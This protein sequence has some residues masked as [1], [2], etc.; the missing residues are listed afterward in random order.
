MV[1]QITGNLT[2][3]WP[4]VQTNIKENINARVTGPLR[5]ETTGDSP[6]QG[7]AIWKAFPCHNVIMTTIIKVWWFHDSLIFMTI[8]KVWWS[9]DRLYFY[10]HNK[11]M[12]V[13]WQ[14]Y[15]YDSLI[16]TSIMKVWWAHD[17]LIFTTDISEHGKMTFVL[18]CSTGFCWKALSGGC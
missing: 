14:S 6:H 7:P 17:N 4:F 5:R 13:S 2:I 12:M 15:F 11:G 18:K 10:D 9:H 8:I 3:C 1:S 16:F